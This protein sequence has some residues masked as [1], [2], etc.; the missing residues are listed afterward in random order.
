MTPEQIRTAMVAALQTVAP[1]V[2]ADQIRPNISL[3]DQFD[4]DSM[5]FLNFVI[6]L[7][8]SLKIAIP[9]ADYPQLTTLDRGIEYLIGRLQSADSSNDTSQSGNWIGSN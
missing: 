2:A 4:I 8:K 5:D 9:E 6:A 1:E 3:R 7:N